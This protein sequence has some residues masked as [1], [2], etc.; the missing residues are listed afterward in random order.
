MLPMPVINQHPA[1]LPD[2]GSDTVALS[3]G[4]VIPALRGAHVV[5]DALALQ[6]PMTGC[7]VHTVVPEVDRGPVLASHEVAILPDDSEETLHSRISSVEQPL[8]ITTLQVLL[9]NLRS[10]R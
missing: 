4:R 3:D 6:L 9:K 5:R 1:L 2:D 10:L 7:T 8:L